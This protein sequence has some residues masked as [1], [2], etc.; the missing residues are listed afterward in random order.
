MQT[1]SIRFQR[2]FRAMI[3]LLAV[4][5][6]LGGTLA[7]YQPAYAA[8][9]DISGRVVK[10]TEG[11]SS[12]TDPYDV[13]LENVHVYL[14]RD[15]GDDEP[16]PGDTLV[17][18]T[19]TSSG[20]Y[21]FLSQ[22]NGTYWIVVESDDVN[23]LGAS[24]EQTYGGIGALVDLD[25]QS[26]TP[27]TFRTTAGPAFGGRRMLVPD[28]FT[29]ET[30]LLDKAEH[31]IR[32]VL[33]GSG[34]VAGHTNLDFGFGFQKGL[35]GGYSEY[36]VPTQMTATGVS[37]GVVATFG[38]MT[39]GIWSILRDLDNDTAIDAGMH[40]II[41]VGASTDST[42]VY[43]DHWEDGYDFDPLNPSTAD[44]TT[45]LN[46][47]QVQT[48]ES[49]NIP[50]NPRGSA[51]YYDGRD[52]IFVAGGLATVTVSVF[53]ETPGSVYNVA[54]EILPIKP[55]QTYYVVPVGEGMAGNG[56][57]DFQQSFLTIQSA[58]NGNTV[59]VDN[60]PLGSVDITQVLNRGEV[61]DV[62]HFAAGAVVQGTAP[63]QVHAIFGY[64]QAGGASEA[65]G[66]T[67]FPRTL[68]DDEYYAPVESA[69]SAANDGGDASLYATEIYLY[70][71]TANP[72]TI[73]YQD[74]AGSGTYVLAANSSTR[75][76]QMA[77]RYV[78]VGS[79][80]YLRST[81]GEKFWAIG[82]SGVSTTN[83]NTGLASGGG[84]VHTYY[85]SGYSLVPGYLLRSDYYMA[86]APGDSTTNATNASSVYVTAISDSTEIF[87]DFNAD[88]VPDAT[89]FDNADADDNPATGTETSYIL[90]RL[91]S[92]QLRDTTNPYSM[93]GTHIWSNGA[94]AA[95]WGPYPRTASYVA[96]SL[97]AA[98]SALP[99]PLE[100]MDAVLGVLK[101]VDAPTHR[102]TVGQ[103]ATFTLAIPAY[104][105]VNDVIATDKLPIGWNFSTGTSNV[106]VTK[107]GA[108]T[109]STTNPAI[110][111]NGTTV[112]ETLTW[113]L[114]T[115]FPGLNLED[116]NPN[117]VIV[118]RFTATTNASVQTGYNQNDTEVC[119][120]RSPGG[121]TQTF[122][123]E[124]KLAVYVT[125]LLIDKDT[126]TPNVLAGGQAI[127]T[128]R[129]Q[130]SDTVNDLTNMRVTDNLPVGFTWTLDKI[131]P[132]AKRDSVAFIGYGQ[133]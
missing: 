132:S 133:K 92:I 72:M 13:G 49:A 93:T 38:Q 87:V 54:W 97:D 23:A 53:P 40:Y 46:K 124:D 96:P 105:A 127:Y 76:T 20:N 60:P 112:R 51:V 27:A 129:L 86:W 42:T 108:T 99:L 1:S 30:K 24:V 56:A 100:W 117:D 103:V 50:W 114:A 16:N 69:G 116:L 12:I 35:A 90:N 47:G 3:S 82:Q 131:V 73:F 58:S 77:T 66:V 36:Y 104:Q 39:G 10:D 110:A 111:G 75:Y 65:D 84:G 22:P 109:T 17:A 25:A 28:G 43:Y 107:G 101:S 14:Y 26:A 120:T 89:D 80:A 78:P 79:A 118:I 63:I 62:R 19:L 70:N 32:V 9:N 123:A 85:D 4:V 98:Y 52:R 29:T 55:L 37:E 33:D 106:A 67:I 121:V 94:T 91:R 81:N 88:G 31:V 44:V 8:P 125:P 71:P 126:T 7:Q 34:P 95:V 122:C 102:P 119:G 15:N 2:L 128:I 64:Y 57:L 18:S 130:N 59:T 41:A 6:L 21:S 83:I 68:W 11:N 115:L 5:G 61:L 48:Y 113:N 45:A 74:T